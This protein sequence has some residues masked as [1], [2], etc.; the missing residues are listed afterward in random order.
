MFIQQH[1]ETGFKEA[2]RRFGEK[3]DLV[4]YYTE[5]FFFCVVKT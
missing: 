4:N 3:L 2:S 1:V 5:Y